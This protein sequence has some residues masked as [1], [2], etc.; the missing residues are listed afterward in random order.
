MPALLVKRV[1]A[2]VSIALLLIWC[3]S[4]WITFLHRSSSGFRA[5]VSG[6]LVSVTVATSAAPTSCS[7]S[8]E[9]L[10]Q[11]TRLGWWPRWYSTPQEWGVSVPL[12]FVVCLAVG[13]TFASAYIANLPRRRVSRGMCWVCKYDRTDTPSNVP[14]PE[15]GSSLRGEFDGSEASALGRGLASAALAK[16]TKWLVTGAAIGCVTVLVL[17][18]AWRPEATGDCSLVVQWGPHRAGIA[19]VPPV[20]QQASERA[21]WGW[22]RSQEGWCIELSVVALAVAGMFA[23]IVLWN[24]PRWLP[25]SAKAIS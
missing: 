6:G 4:V 8:S 12:W 23:T 9:F 1:T 13:A 19:W 7:P 22:F 18:I 17:G 10:F 14:C 16:S 2:V 11:H 5:S 15:C 3:S 21:Q 24:L 25:R 20:P